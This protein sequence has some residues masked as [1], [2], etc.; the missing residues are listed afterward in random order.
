MRL[1]NSIGLPKES[2][3]LA[4]LARLKR[5]TEEEPR[6][7][8]V[9]KL[10]DRRS[11]STILPVVILSEVGGGGP[12]GL[13]GPGGGP[14]GGGPEGGPGRFGVQLQ[15]LKLSIMHLYLFLLVYCGLRI[16]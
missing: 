10:L 6:S 11:I 3:I 7:L 1:A 15:S 16:R 8:T 13:G 4:F 14:H 12:G 9:V 5:M 2:K